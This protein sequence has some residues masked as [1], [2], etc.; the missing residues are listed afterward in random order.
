MRKWY[1][2]AQNIDILHK[3]RRC[4][5]DIQHNNNQ[6]HQCW[7][8]VVLRAIFLLSC[9]MSLYWVSLGWMLWHQKSIWSIAT[10][11]NIAL[12]TLLFY[13]LFFFYKKIRFLSQFFEAS[14]TFRKLIEK[15]FPIS[16]SESVLKV[17]LVL[18][19]FIKLPFH[20]WKG[21]ITW[22]D[23]RTS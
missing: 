7:L 4:I 12:N 16:D 15:S 8:S 11:N 14:T 10:I 23:L 6:R 18:G 2:I 21:N 22:T 1:P 5:N 20:C 3:S 17:S 19:H 13:T 9:S